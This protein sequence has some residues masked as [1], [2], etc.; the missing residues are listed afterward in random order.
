MRVFDLPKAAI[1]LEAV[2]SSPGEW[3]SRRKTQFVLTDTR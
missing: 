3:T 1:E 2:V